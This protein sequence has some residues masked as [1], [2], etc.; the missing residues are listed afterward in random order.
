MSA[1]S[2]DKH[3]LTESRLPEDFTTVI[4]RKLLS[5]ALLLL[6]QAVKPSPRSCKKSPSYGWSTEI[7]FELQWF[8]VQNEITCFIQDV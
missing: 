8:L 4:S 5:S 6:D 1:R 7:S 3:L 2:T